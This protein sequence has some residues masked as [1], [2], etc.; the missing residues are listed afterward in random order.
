MFQ[1][2]ASVAVDQEQSTVGSSND[3][4][5]SQNRDEFVA[6]RSDQ[7]VIKEFSSLQPPAKKSKMKE[8]R[9]SFYSLIQQE[10]ELETFKSQ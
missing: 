7:E 9:S 2:Y 6:L 5:S 4:A 3:A 8:R 10:M 1:R